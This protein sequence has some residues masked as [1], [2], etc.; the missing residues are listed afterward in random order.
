MYP[1]FNR[2]N[3]YISEAKSLLN[4][5]RRFAD[6]F[7]S[8]VTRNKKRVAAKYVNE[9]GKIKSYKYK[10]FE[11]NVKTYAYA[12]GRKL[13][14][15]EGNNVVVLKHANAPAWPELFY[16]ILM[17]GYKP[18][19]VDA[20]TSKEGTENLIR[21]TGAIGI[22]TDDMYLYEIKKLNP[23]EL[24]EMKGIAEPKWENEV[25][26]CSSGTT[27][28]VKLMV[29][30]G[31]NFCHQICCSLKMPLETKDIMYPKSLGQI[32]ILAM[33]PFH[34][35]FGFVAVFLWYTFYGCALVYPA[36]LT[37]S[38]LQSVCQK[39]GVTHVYSVPLFWDSLALQTTRKFSLLDQ[40]KQELIKKMMAYNIGEISK[41][42][43]GKASMSIV[44]KTVQKNILGSAVRYCISGGGFLSTET[45]R[46]INGLGYN[47]YNGFG[48]TEI[49][50]T[51]VELSS[52]VKVRLL[53]RIGKPL[54]GVEY[55]IV[56]NQLFV[57]SPT[58]HVREIIG[59][60]ERK[61]EFDEEGFFPTG[62]IAEVDEFGAYT[63]KG[64]QKDVIIN[65]D[66]E[67]IFPD[68]LEIYFKDLPHITHLCVLGIAK[69]SK[70]HA[71]DVALVLETDNS[72][73]DDD[74]AAIEKQ[75]KEIEPKLP[76]KVKIDA[77]YLSKGRLPLANNMKVKRFVIKKA[78][79]GDTGEYLPLHQKQQVKKFAGFDKKTIEEILVPVKET[80]SKVL[81]LPAYKIEDDAHWINDLGGDSMSYVELIK[82]LQD[83]FDIAF[84]EETLG[85]MA[86]V[87]DFV[88]EIAQLKKGNK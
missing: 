30:N 80:F 42:E 21:Q 40:G 19:L 4:T 61:T 78:I 44:R 75:I 41:E 57:K 22:I 60:K 63:L 20:R 25:I 12:I 72:I 74:I 24:L 15:I 86:T 73:T 49:G 7:Q 70:S 23:E 64:R 58:I 33:V 14:N 67:N 54:N 81:V 50:V 59:G 6:I 39:A 85:V 46:T 27:G 69:N 34:H 28:D 55:K 66:G 13:K 52:D 76:H 5:Q 51:S 88:Y 17:A 10:V 83:Q 32:N 71:E 68:E 45:L 38:D 8:I 16:G 26:F 3:E 29:F 87:N 82:E 84:K 48:M 1:E 65:A 18:L 62:D 9:K 56:D 37:P 79:E 2:V 11:L 35:I 31:E 47:L 53:G 77:T 36:S 43:A